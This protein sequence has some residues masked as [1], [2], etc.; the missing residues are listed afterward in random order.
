MEE[1]LLDLMLELALN[2]KQK[3]PDLC[4]P[5]PV[6]AGRPAPETPSCSAPG[7]SGQPC[8]H[9]DSHAPTVHVRDVVPVMDQ[10]CEAPAEAARPVPTL[11]NPSRLPSARSAQLQCARPIWPALCTRTPS[12]NN[13]AGMC[14]ISP[15]ASAESEAEAARPV[16]AQASPSRPPSTRN[17]PLQCA[18]PIWPALCTQ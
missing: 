8:A 15:W 12:G 13:H 16:P 6:Q 5:R 17:A 14:L 3:Q 1:S 9:S 18:R 10:C 7:P 4:P 11:A 2:L